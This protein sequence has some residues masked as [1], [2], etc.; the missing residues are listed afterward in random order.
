MIRWEERI[1]KLEVFGDTDLPSKTLEEELWEGPLRIMRINQE[2]GF[3]GY[4]KPDDRFEISYENE[5]FLSKV[6]KKHPILG[7]LS[8]ILRVESI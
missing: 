1:E 4:V 3:A 7:Y 2:H 6:Y 5:E 8:Q